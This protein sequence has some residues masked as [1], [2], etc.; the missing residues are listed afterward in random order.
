MNKESLSWEKPEIHDLG[1]AADLIQGQNVVGGGDAQ[2]N[3]LL[4]S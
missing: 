4:P 2:F 3:I 1:S